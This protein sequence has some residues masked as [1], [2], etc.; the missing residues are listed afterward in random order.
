MTLRPLL[1]LPELP[2]KPLVSVLIASWNYGRFVGAAIESALRQSYENLEVVVVDDG[3]TDDSCRVVQGYADRDLRVRLIR[4]PNGGAA[5][6]LNRAFAES[7]GEI[8]CFLD[9]DDLW[10]SDKL[11]RIVA[12]F[13][14]HPDS[15][16]ATHPLE[17]IDGEGRRT[18]EFRCV[19]GGL[20]GED[21]ATLRMGHLFPVSSGLSFRRAVLDH[22]MP[23][24]EERFRSAADLA[25]AYAAAIL[26]RTTF[27]PQM[28]ASYRVH[29]DNLTGTTLTAARVD[30][31][32]V[33]K[34]LSGVERTVMFADEFSREHLGQPISPSRSRNVL[35]HRLLLALLAGDSHL[36]QQ[37]SAD[38]NQAFAEVRRD[39]PV[40]RLRF[41]QALAAL[42]PPLTRV[43]LQGVFRLLRARSRLKACQR[44]TLSLRKLVRR[45]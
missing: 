35:E 25:I 42:P 8:V 19:D 10:A 3:S 21:I 26:T 40:L 5:S 12:A 11:A 23:I 7:H 15:G 4:K 1:P 16:L 39:Y 37:A 45:R 9:A 17:I 29:G 44:Q 6:A 34:I 33:R 36:L 32:F 24:P 27:L 20:L 13:R 22:V 18:G 38:L 2:P 41:W 43:A 28:L 14:D 31:D 30:A